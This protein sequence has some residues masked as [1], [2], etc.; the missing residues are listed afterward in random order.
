MDDYLNAS[1]LKYCGADQNTFHSELLKSGFDERQ[2]FLLHDGAQDK[3]LL[4]FR[5]NIVRQ[6]E[7]VLGFA[8]PGD[9]VMIGFSGHGIHLGRTSYLCPTDA[10]LDDA[11]TLVSLDW[12]YEKLQRCR[13]DLRLVMVD[14]CRNDPR[15]DGQRVLTSEEFREGARAF[16]QGSFRLPDG[17]ILLNSCSEGEI[18][19][20]DA[21]IGH[22]V[23]MHFVLKGLQ[24]EADR[25]RDRQVTLDE[26]VKYASKET[27]IY[28]EKKYNDSQRPKLRG[29]YNPDAMEVSLRVLD[30]L[31]PMNSKPTTSSVSSD[32]P[33]EI[34]SNSTGMKLMLIPAGEFM[35][36]SSES[37][38]E[39]TSRFPEETG[40]YS[41]EHPQQRVKISKPFYLGQHEVTLK[42]FLIFYHDAKYK[43]ECERDGKETGGY[44]PNSEKKFVKKSG[45]RP[46]KWGFE[47]QTQHHP[48]VLVTWNDAKAFCEWLSAKDGVQYRLP[49]EAEWEY[50]CRAGSQTRYN[51]GADPE[52]LSHYANV[53]DASAL[54]KFEWF[55][56]I[57]SDDG[58]VFTAPVGSFPANAWGL[59]DM[60]GNAQEMCQDWY[61]KDYYAEFVGKVV[62]DPAGPRSGEKRVARGGLWCKGPSFARS[63]FRHANSQSFSGIGTGFRV[64]AVDAGVGSR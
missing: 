61:S 7:T 60:H 51:F 56:G 5:A 50:A 21:S 46:W 28:V 27:K 4:P 13:A 32:L 43:A 52:Q 54:S 63:A 37:A 2:V 41:D 9:F 36:G 8:D 29:N 18:S 33:S 53:G 19:Q 10:K 6:I 59:H 24:G 49:M 23:F 62:T 17:V 40:D 58:F 1:D 3:K 38:G 57:K 11:T 44:E 42:E 45:F 30:R 20:E 47:G 55:K 14:A 22:G 64:V 12:I 39:I 35:M 48:V 31:D 15:P 26:L 16:V 25:D 34:T